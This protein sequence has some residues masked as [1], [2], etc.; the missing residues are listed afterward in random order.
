MFISSTFNSIQCKWAQVD[1]EAYAIIW[2]VKKLYQFVY[3]REFTLITDNRAIKQIFS[4]D[5]SLPIFSALRMQHY[6]IFLRGFQYKIEFKK[7]ELNAN[8]DCLS[9]LSVN[10]ESE[11]IDVVD[12][13]FIN[14]IS[15]IPVTVNDILKEITK[16]S[17]C[18][19]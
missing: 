10:C 7:S 11:N 19:R 18:S 3:G 13:F 16:D 17:K 5:K 1:K 6:A 4:P 9:R 12:F 8:A 2:A 15:E 14:M